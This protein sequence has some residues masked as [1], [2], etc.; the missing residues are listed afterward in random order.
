MENNYGHNMSRTFVGLILSFSSH[1]SLY[2]YFRQVDIV[3]SMIPHDPH[4]VPFLY[5]GGRFR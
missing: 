4:D 3:I 2:I 1:I 5:K